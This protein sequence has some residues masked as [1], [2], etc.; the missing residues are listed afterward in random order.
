[1]ATLLEKIGATKKNETRQENRTQNSQ[2]ERAAEGQRAEGPQAPSPGADGAGHVDGDMCRH[3]RLA[4]RVTFTPGTLAAD[5]ETFFECVACR[6]WF[7]K[8]ELESEFFQR[9]GI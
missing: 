7:T 8:E 1:M 4:K 5:A 6:Q 9:K 2:I 3:D